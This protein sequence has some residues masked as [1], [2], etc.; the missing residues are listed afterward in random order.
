MGFSYHL[1][2]K[3]VSGG[4]NLPAYSHFGELWKAE[5]KITQVPLKKGHREANSHFRG[6]LHSVN[7][8]SRARAGCG[9]DSTKLSAVLTAGK[10]ST[11]RHLVTVACG[12][13]PY[14]RAAPEVAEPTAS[15]NFKCHALK[16]CPLLFD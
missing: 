1:L 15:G 13:P 8:S 10:L 7:A 2:A 12:L 14:Y 11:A 4:N 16:L 6:V 5:C 3:Q 9:E